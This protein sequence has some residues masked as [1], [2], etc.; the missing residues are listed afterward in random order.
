[1]FLAL[2]PDTTPRRESL[3]SQADVFEFFMSVALE[4]SLSSGG[5]F[6]AGYPVIFDDFH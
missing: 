2:A 6:G 3:F 4:L 5:D 1:M